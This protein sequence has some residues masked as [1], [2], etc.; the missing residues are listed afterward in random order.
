MELIKSRHI[1]SQYL[2][3]KSPADMQNGIVIGAR[4]V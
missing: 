2:D 3:K 1:V 4:T